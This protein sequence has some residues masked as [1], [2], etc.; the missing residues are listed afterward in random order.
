MNV[1][2]T[3]ILLGLALLLAS[4]QASSLKAEGTSTPAPAKPA[5]TPYEHTAPTNPAL[6]PPDADIWKQTWHD[7]KRPMPP[8]STPL[9]EEEL[10]ARSKAPS[11]A[12]VLFDGKD[13]SAWQPSNWIVKDGYMEVATNSAYLVSKQPFGSMKLHLEWLS[14]EPKPGQDGQKRNN[15]GVFPM[16]L[17]E[18]QV[19]DTYNNTN[20]YADGIAGSIYGQYPP[21]SNPIRPPGHWQYYDI[22]FHHPKFD[23]K[24]NLTRAAHVTLDFNGVRVQDNV[25]IIG[26]TSG[27]ARRAYAAH[28]EALPLQLQYHHDPARF[29]NIWAVPIE[30]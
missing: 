17:Y 16:G 9:P 25:T 8:V 19:L 5:P 23:A 14:P 1:S 26:P 2:T 15:S 7:M 6:P 4:L 29:R 10:A 24:G 28:P 30:D 12:I 22:T 13:L 21:I 11:N 3:R 18:I 20:T 27:A